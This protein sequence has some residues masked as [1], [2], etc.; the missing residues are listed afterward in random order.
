MKPRYF[1]TGDHRFWH[2]NVI[3]EDYEDRPFKDDNGDPDVI[4]MNQ[5]M[6]QTWNDKITD[7]DVVCYLGNFSFGGYKKTLDILSKLSGKLLYVRG[8]HDNKAALKALEQS[9]KL[10]APVTYVK[11]I[12]VGTQHIVLSHHPYEIWF[13]CTYGTWNIHGH[14][15][16]K[17]EEKGKKMDV[18]VD[19]I[20]DKGLGY[21]PVPFEYVQGIL[22]SRRVYPKE[23][24]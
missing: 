8:N 23:I 2:K 13:G 19:A 7:N 24:Y 16:G 20:A 1:F 17:C 4:L 10:I 18:G 9:G 21:A 11:E 6:I 22:D 14:C 5:K 3:K 15:H 12:K